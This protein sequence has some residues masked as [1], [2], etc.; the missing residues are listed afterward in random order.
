MDTPPHPALGN[1]VGPAAVLSNVPP[2]YQPVSVRHLDSQS[3]SEEPQDYLWLVNCESKKPEPNRWVCFCMCKARIFT[4]LEYYSVT[5]FSLYIFPVYLV[6]FCTFHLCCHSS[7]SLSCVM[8]S[9]VQLHSSLEGD[10]EYLLLEECESKPLPPQTSLWV[11][12]HPAGTACLCGVLHMYWKKDKSTETHEH[13]IQSAVDLHGFYRW[14]LVL[15][16]RCCRSDETV[17]ILSLLACFE[18]YSPSTKYL[19]PS[20]NQKRD[21]NIARGVKEYW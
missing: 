17:L 19:S 3:S 10:W 21:A 18:I 13:F 12:S 4:V 8:C 7:P 5:S 15:D 1:I 9:S 2:P 20:L 16:L 6:I 11:A 14:L